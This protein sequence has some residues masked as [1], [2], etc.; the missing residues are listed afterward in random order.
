MKIYGN[1][2]VNGWTTFE[3]LGNVCAREGIVI[4]CSLCAFNYI[5]YKNRGHSYALC[6]KTVSVC[7]QS[8]N[9]YLRVCSVCKN[10][11][12]HVAKLTR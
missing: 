6:T 1:K 8:S 7:L 3:F 10:Y 2:N 11:S 5:L 12:F 9:K 4:I